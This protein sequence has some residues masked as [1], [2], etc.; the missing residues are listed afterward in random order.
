MAARR[1]PQLMEKVETAAANPVLKNRGFDDMAQQHRIAA[2]AG[3]AASAGDHNVASPCANPCTC[4]A[5]A[6]R[7]TRKLDLLDAS[8]RLLMATSR[9]DGAGRQTARRRH[10]PRRSGRRGRA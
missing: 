9:A 5:I 4:G 6:L 10:R 3:A 7:V 8:A 1:K 2:R